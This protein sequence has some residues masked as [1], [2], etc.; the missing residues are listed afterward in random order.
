M[1]NVGCDVNHPAF[2]G[3]NFVK[4][5]FTGSAVSWV[6]GDVSYVHAARC[7]HPRM[8]PPCLMLCCWLACVFAYLVCA[9]T[10]SVGHAHARA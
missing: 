5:D 7:T 1:T 2:N 6:I 4:K 8:H 10:C 9:T 3:V